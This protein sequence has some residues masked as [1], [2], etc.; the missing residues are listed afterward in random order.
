MHV[1]LLLLLCSMS[2]L[3][4]VGVSQ[5]E[6][7]IFT[8]DSLYT[9]VNSV[10]NSPAVQ[11]CDEIAQRRFVESLPNGAQCYSGL[12]TLPNP[13]ASPDAVANALANVCND[14]CGG[15][16]SKFLELPCNSPIGAENLRVTCTPTNG[17]AAVGN[18]CH[19]ALPLTPLVIF[20]EL[21][22]CDNVSSDTSCSPGCRETLVKLKSQLGCCLQTVY[23]NTIYDAELFLEGGFL[24][25]S[26]FEN[27]QR[28]ITP[29]SN[30]WTIC[31]VKPPERCGAPL[32]KPPA[33]PTCL[34]EDHVYFIA[35]LPNAA[36]CGQ[37]LGVVLG[38]PA[39]DSA[40]LANAL[41]NVCTSECGGAYTEFLKSTCNDQ[42]TA[43]FIRISCIRTHG[44]SGVGNYCRPGLEV[45]LSITSPLSLIS[46]QCRDGICPPGCRA[47]VLEL[48]PLIGCCYQDIL[49]NSFFYQQQ[50]LN[51]IIT[52][53][54]FEDFVIF[55]GPYTS[56]FRSCNV[57]V[58][59]KCPIEPPSIGK[60][61]IESMGS[62]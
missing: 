53:R 15:I 52:L 30:L 51:G 21:S 6:S 58:P 3:V 8:T 59:D 4:H 24:T 60:R 17:T 14:D 50:V 49:N 42:F 7:E 38:V 32:F 57:P 10:T 41:E 44:N 18:F 5:T 19:F 54:D 39:N 35:S 61:M 27:L 16:F 9:G 22:S 37:S 31:E 20:N 11:M 62:L 1:A 26:Q 33:P 45:L 29:D 47:A 48:Q 28:L 34:P 23:N 25:Q 13:L 36:V 12:N 40:E 55:N 56:P 2:T 43:E 46:S